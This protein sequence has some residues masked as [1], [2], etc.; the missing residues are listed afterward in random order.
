MGQGGR[1]QKIRLETK[2]EA[3]SHGIH[4]RQG[5]V[6]LSKGN[7]RSFEGSKQGWVSQEGMRCALIIKVLKHYMRLCEEWR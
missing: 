2:A 1:Q 7:I 5:T 4:S 3:R 6:N